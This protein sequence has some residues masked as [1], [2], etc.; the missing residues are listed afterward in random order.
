MK[1]LVLLKLGG[2]LITDKTKVFQARFDIIHRLASELKDASKKMSL[3]VGHG[4]GSFPHIAAKEYDV[5]KGAKDP[6]NHVGFA[7]TQDAAS[8]LNRIV[9]NV[10]LENGIKAVSVQPS[11]CLVAK[12]GQIHEMFVE[13]VRMLLE[14]NMVP[15]PYGDA[16]LDIDSGYCII[17][18]EKILDALSDKFKVKMVINLGTVDGVFKSQ[19]GKGSLG[20]I[21]KEINPDNFDDIKKYIGGSNGTDVTGGMIHK[22]MQYLDL[23]K[24]GPE[25]WIINGLVPGRLKDALDG[26]KVIGTKIRA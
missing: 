13:P 17:S 22:V 1:D 14:L 25:V 11:S 15:I 3:I 10:M 7:Y 2:S 8:R 26:K 5:H 4:G 9:V 20:E 24:K 6:T 19:S 12:K 21:I 16:C 18:T 23:A